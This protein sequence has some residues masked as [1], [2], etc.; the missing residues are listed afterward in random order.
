MK[1][2]S[3]SEIDTLCRKVVE[4]AEQFDIFLHALFNTLYLTG[5]RAGEVIDFSRWSVDTAGNFTVL[6]EKNSNPRTF[7]SDELDPLFADIITT[8]NTH[9]I[10]FNYKY[11][12]RTFNKFATYSQLFIGNKQV[13][14]HL[15]RHNKAKRMILEGYTDTQIQSYLGEKDIKNALS[16][17]NSEVFTI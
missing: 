3:V 14:T 6:T 12:Q 13:S 16:Y 5:L 4:T 1:I 11:L 10:T 15:F 7:A 2:L 8:Q 17:I 9:L